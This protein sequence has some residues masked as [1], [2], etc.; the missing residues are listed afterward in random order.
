MLTLVVL[1]RNKIRQRLGPRA[2]TKPHG[3]SRSAGRTL[4]VNSDVGPKI[5]LEQPPVDI[6]PVLGPDILTN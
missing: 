1:A 4:K 6:I 3:I 2:S 5:L